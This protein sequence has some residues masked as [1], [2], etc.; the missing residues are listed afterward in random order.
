MSSV[1]PHVISGANSV[2]VFCAKHVAHSCAVKWSPS[3]MQAKVGD[4][5]LLPRRA[6]R[7]AEMG[8]GAPRRTFWKT[9]VMVGM[10]ASDLK[11]AE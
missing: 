8:K 7:S 2:A 11:K 6:A 10:E 3:S 9:D 1:F 5:V 4:A